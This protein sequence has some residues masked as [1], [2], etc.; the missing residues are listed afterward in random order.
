M[1]IA[2]EALLNYLG[3]MAFSMPDGREIFTVADLEQHFT[4]ERVSLGGP[5]FDLGKLTWL[6]GRYIRDVL[7]LQDVV[8]RSKTHLEQAGFDVSDSAKLEKVIHALR[9]RFDVF[10]D[11]PAKAS[12]FYNDI[13]L[14][15]KAATKLKEGK[16]HLAALLPILEQNTT[17]DGLALETAIKAY[18]ETSGIKLGAVMQPLRAALTGKLESPGMVEL[19]EALGQDLVLERVKK[20][21]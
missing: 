10:S 19:L 14:E 13:V 6:N 4:W 16:V 17:W 2:P 20:A 11:L 3:M 8:A 21:L 7:T 15:E 18:A 5:V 12:Y 9:P 1:G